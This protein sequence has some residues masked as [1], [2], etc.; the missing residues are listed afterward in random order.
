MYIYI[1]TH[2]IECLKI[3]RLNDIYVYIYTH[4]YIRTYIYIYIHTYTHAYGTI[5][6]MNILDSKGI[7]LKQIIL[8]IPLI[9][10][11]EECKKYVEIAWTHSTHG[12]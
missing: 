4:T 9:F 12:G 2:T 5:N 7:L 8:N 1:Y 11:S 3:I 10:M 6:V